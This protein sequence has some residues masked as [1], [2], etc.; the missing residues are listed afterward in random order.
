MKEI[1]SF[2][3]AISDDGKTVAVAFTATYSNI[4]G[5]QIVKQQLDGVLPH[6]GMFR[7]LIY[8]GYLYIARV[9]ENNISEEELV[10]ALNA[11]TD[12]L[13]DVELVSAAGIVAMF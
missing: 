5:Q 3:Y 9:Y 1:N 13:S 10:V 7:D 11:K 2:L 12:R 4:A 8:N 6:T